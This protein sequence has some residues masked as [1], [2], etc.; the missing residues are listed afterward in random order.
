M[1][2]D[3]KLVLFDIDGTLIRTNTKSVAHWKKRLQAVFR[4]IFA[5]EIGDIDL[6]IVNGKLERGYFHAIATSFG[7]SD[8][9][10]YEKFTDASELFHTKLKGT[11]EE[12]HVTYAIIEGVKPLVSHIQKASHLS[13]GLVTGNIEKNAWL[14]LQSVDFAHPFEVGAYGDAFEDRKELVLHA[15][16]AASTQFDYPYAPSDTIVVGDT[17]HDIHSAKKIGAFALGVTTGFTD[18]REMLSASG[19]DLVVDTLM[20]ERVLSLLGLT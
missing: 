4:E 7:V 20:D 18:T 19:A 2:K 13:M 3:K 17:T 10:F 14:K 15:I 6:S 12:G 5:V 9:L 8:E 1:K 16:K 11:I